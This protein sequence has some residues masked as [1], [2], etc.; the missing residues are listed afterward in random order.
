MRYLSA[1]ILGLAAALSGCSGG[2]GGGDSGNRI[3]PTVTLQVTPTA[4]TAGATATL[5]WDST[6]ATDCMASGGWSG[7]RG[8]SGSE[9]TGALP[10]STSHTLTCT[11]PGGTAARTVTVTVTGPPA[12]TVTLGAT[13]TTINA[14]AAS[15]LDWSA[16]NAGTCTASGSWNGAQPLS[17]SRSTGALAGN[18]SYTLTCIGPGGTGSQTAAVTV[19]PAVGV[20]TVNLTA[21]PSNV[22]S[23]TAATLSWS[24]SNATACTASGGWSGS[25]ATSGSF[26]TG[27]LVTAT[28]Y[29]LTC[30]GA[31]GSASQTV[32]VTVTPPPPTVNVAANPASV[33]SG[34]VSNLTWSSSNATTCAASG[35]WSGARA[36][37]GT[38]S[39]GPLTTTTS[40]TLACSGPG[41]TVNRSVTVSITGATAS[42]GLNFPGS[43]AV[44]TTM[45]FRFLN[46]LAIYPATYIW[47]AY[48]RQQAGY[49]TAFFWGNDDGQEDLSTFLWVGP[50]EADS[51]Y[52]AHPYPDG[53]SAAQ[54]HQW[55]ISV[56]Q[57]DYVNGVVVYDRWYTQAL[58]VWSDSSGR[59]HH[60]FYWD[61]PNTDASHMVSRTAPSDWGNR[62]PPVPALTWGDAPWAPGREVWNGILRGIQVYSANLSLPEILTEANAP[63]STSNGAA[64]IWYLNLDPTPTDISDKSGQGNEP[65]WVGPE[66]PTLWTAP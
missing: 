6:A 29:T 46:P 15:D 34:S 11:G 19:I 22:L 48:P 42:F 40:F 13:P 35:G 59:K 61:L 8:S 65:E 30:T 44:S 32:T 33:V 64:N 49:Y 7:S 51:Y 4:I 66:R 28:S 58:R 26:G 54:T 25:R 1:L 14:G 9:T 31:G 20:P 12:P 16:T 60:E 63:L 2:G 27:N 43:A 18:A 57:A 47:R 56:L 36:T 50:S 3:P 24:S 17:G 55:E 41:G 10:A 38:A 23:G 52:G 62:N 45:R 37:S 53:G 5:T 39:T 21:T